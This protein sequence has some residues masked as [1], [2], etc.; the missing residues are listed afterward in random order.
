MILS[1]LRSET[2]SVARRM[3]Q[4]LRVNDIVLGNV[5]PSLEKKEN[6]V[7]DRE[8]RS[9]PNASHI[10]VDT[11]RLATGLFMLRQ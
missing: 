11:P 6:K 1:T 7:S 10:N 3:A 2:T 9:A 4:A 8:G 5:R